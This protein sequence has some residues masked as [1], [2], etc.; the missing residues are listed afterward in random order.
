R[1]NDPHLGRAA[2]VLHRSPFSSTRGLT[3]GATETTLALTASGALLSL[4]AGR[5]LSLRRAW[6]LPLAAGRLADPRERPVRDHEHVVALGRGDLR[7][8]GHAG[9]HAPRV[10]EH[11]ADLI[12]HHPLGRGAGGG[13]RRNRPLQGAP[14]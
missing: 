2:G 12:A 11:D 1:R 6:C 5:R 13:D 8:S 3:T 4:G 10:A 7:G 14:T 9:P